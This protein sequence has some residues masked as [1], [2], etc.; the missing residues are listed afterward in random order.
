MA[1][2]RVAI[3]GRQFHGKNGVHA[4]CVLVLEAP[5][6]LKRVEIVLEAL[7]DSIERLTSMP[8]GPFECEP[9]PEQP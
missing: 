7:T 3:V 8:P 4:V 9:P 1:I 6:A 5:S 2:L